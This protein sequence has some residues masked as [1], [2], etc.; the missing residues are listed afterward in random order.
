VTRSEQEKGR[1]EERTAMGGAFLNGAKW[2]GRRGG[3]AG[4]G[5][6]QVAMR[7][8]GVPSSIGRHQVAGNGLAVVLAVGQLL[9]HAADA[10]QGRPGRRHVGPGPQ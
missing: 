10:K 5:R 1:E 8:G 6:H 9:R 3:G 2:G 7:W 4:D